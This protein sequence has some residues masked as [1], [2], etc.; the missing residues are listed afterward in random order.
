MLSIWMCQSRCTFAVRHATGSQR[1][2]GRSSSS[3]RSDCSNQSR[4]LRVSPRNGV[5]PL[6]TSTCAAIA[7]FNSSSDA[8][9][10]S[11]R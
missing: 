6:M 11:A 2:S 10:R 5:L 3:C 8:N 4:R 7:S 1:C 9:V